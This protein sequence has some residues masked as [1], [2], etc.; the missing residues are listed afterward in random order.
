MFGTVCPHFKDEDTD[1]GGRCNLPKVIDSASN[2]WNPL[3]PDTCSLSHLLSDL[4]Y[5]LLSTRP[6]SLSLSKIA[7]L[8]KPLPCFIFLRCI[9]HLL[10]IWSL[11]IYFCIVCSPT[12]PSSRYKFHKDSHFSL[13]LCRRLYPWYLDWCLAYRKFSSMPVEEMNNSTRT[14][15]LGSVP[16]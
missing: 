4:L 12:L 8:L 2:P 13:S 5:H 7:G 16:S 15:M 1:L 11:H 9:D 14:L 10:T 6:S 3:T